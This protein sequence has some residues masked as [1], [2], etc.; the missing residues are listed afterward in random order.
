[1]RSEGVTFYLREVK[2]KNQRYIRVRIFRFD[3]DK[4]KRGKLQIYRVPKVSEGL[5]TGMNILEYIYNDLDPTI[6]FYRSC[7][8]GVCG[9]CRILIDGKPALSCMTIIKGD[10]T[11]KPI[12]GYEIIRDLVVDFEARTKKPGR[13]GTSQSNYRGRKRS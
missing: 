8:G 3:P 9:G 12:P 7:R 5:Q 4:D 6:A 13:E 1:M 10:V 2:M 11:F